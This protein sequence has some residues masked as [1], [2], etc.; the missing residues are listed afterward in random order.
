MNKKIIPILFAL[1]AASFYALNIP[2][3][4]LLMGRI[5]PTMMAGLL[6]FGAGIGIGI[7]FLFNYKKTKREE[8]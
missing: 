7:M 6:Y 4:K 1:L 3:S 8:R 5:E 2:I